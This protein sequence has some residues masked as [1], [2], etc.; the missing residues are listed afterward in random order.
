MQITRI[1]SMGSQ[2]IQINLMGVTTNDD[3]ELLVI[4]KFEP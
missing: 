1:G 3:L 2:V 4:E